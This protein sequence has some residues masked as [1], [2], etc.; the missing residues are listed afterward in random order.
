[1]NKKL[2]AVIVVVVGALIGLIYSIEN[3]ARPISD[4]TGTVATGGES[5]A[6]AAGMPG[7]PGMPGG[8]GG[9]PPV[10]VPVAGADPHAG[11]NHAPGE[12]HGQ[13]PAAPNAPAASPDPHAGHNH[14]P[15]QGH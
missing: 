2:M 7:M 9:P 11:H 3:T 4:R 6:P 15:G 10:G 8:P 5:A 13:A 1:M 12:G 14:P